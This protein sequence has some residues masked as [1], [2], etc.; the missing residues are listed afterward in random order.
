MRGGLVQSFIEELRAAQNVGDKPVPRASACVQLLAAD[1]QAQVCGAVLNEL[2]ARVS[3]GKDDE[4]DV[5]LERSLLRWRQAIVHLEGDEIVLAPWRARVSTEVVFAGGEESVG[6]RTQ[7]AIAQAR[8]PV[9][10]C[11][12]ER[13][14]AATSQHSRT[15]V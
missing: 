3:A 11:A 8:G 4:L 10:A 13:F 6:G 2:Q 1:K 7:I 9:G 14:D 5:M 12:G 15:C